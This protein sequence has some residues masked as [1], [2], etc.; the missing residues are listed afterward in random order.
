MLNDIIYRM[1]RVLTKRLFVI[2]SVEVCKA[3][4]VYLVISV[5]MIRVLTKHFFCFLICLIWLKNFFHSPESPRFVSSRK[6]CLF[7]YILIWLKNSFHSLK[8][9]VPSLV[10]NLFL[11]H[12]IKRLKN[13]SLRFLQFYLR[14]C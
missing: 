7:S 11:K 5:S 14:M 12:Q 2:L 8:T 13:R 10:K 3:I 1:V 9:S 6:I 4:F